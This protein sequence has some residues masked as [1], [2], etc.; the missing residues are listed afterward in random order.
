MGNDDP[1]PPWIT[2]LL[3]CFLSDLAFYDTPLGV[4]S[5]LTISILH[6]MHQQHVD[7][8]RIPVL[9]LFSERA[10]CIRILVCRGGQAD[11]MC[12]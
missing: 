9:M 6:I 1:I 8:L 2:L 11:P 12:S 10:I 4:N 5:L 7:V 3:M